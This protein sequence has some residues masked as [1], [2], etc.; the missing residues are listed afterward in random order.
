MPMI[1][2]CDMHSSI[3]S[4][5]WRLGTCFG[6]TCYSVSTLYSV[7]VGKFVEKIMYSKAQDEYM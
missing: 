2:I 3:I 4:T 5:D 7:A 1:S 6:A